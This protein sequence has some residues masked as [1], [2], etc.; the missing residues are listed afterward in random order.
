LHTRQGKGCD[1][2]LIAACRQPGGQPK[3]HAVAAIEQ[4]DQQIESDHRKNGAVAA[5][6]Q[7]VAPQQQPAQSA[8]VS[9]VREDV[10]PI[11]TTEVNGMN[12]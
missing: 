7:R 4:R 2:G 5:V 10:L 3:N 12:V 11:P 6:T 8:W 1:Q 9:A